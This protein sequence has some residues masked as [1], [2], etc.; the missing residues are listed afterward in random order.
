[1]KTACGKTGAG[2]VLAFG[3]VVALAALGGAPDD[4]PLRQVVSGVDIYLGIVP[5]EIIRG[6][7]RRHPER[8]M[9]DA[10]T[11]G[12]FHVMVALF[13]Q[14][15][16]KRITDAEVSVRLGVS[17]RPGP[18]TRLEPMTIADV[19]TYGNYVDMARGGSYR[20]DVQI[21]RPGALEPIR[22]TF[23]WAAR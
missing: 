23:S 2:T 16:G 10:A 4:N 21:R 20:I 5:A 6:H 13:D 8:K 22:A 7:P 14:A 12:G 15:T 19:L 17:S 11:A 3:L 1:M 9:H 18:E